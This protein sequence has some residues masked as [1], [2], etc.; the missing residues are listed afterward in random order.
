MLSTHASVAEMVLPMSQICG[1]ATTMAMA[2]LEEALPM[3]EGEGATVGGRPSSCRTRKGMLE[4]R[5]LRVRGRFRSPHAV[6]DADELL[7]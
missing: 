4:R 5:L 1:P 6:D 2:L 3:Q 7:K